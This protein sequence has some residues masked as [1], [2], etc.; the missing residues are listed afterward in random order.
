MFDS[1][2]RNQINIRRF[3]KKFNYKQIIKVLS[4]FAVIALILV[5]SLAVPV[6]ALSNVYQPKDYISRIEYEGN[7]EIV[8]YNFDVDPYYSVRNEA[9]GSTTND[10]GSVSIENVISQ[11]RYVFRIYP[12]GN[13]FVPGSSISGGV[14]DIRD[15]KSKAVFNFEV[16]VNFNIQYAYKTMAAGTTNFYFLSSVYFCFYDADGGFISQVTSSDIR[17]DVKLISALLEGTGEEYVLDISA[18][19]QI[20]ENAVYMAPCILSYLYPPDQN[21]DHLITRMDCDTKGFHLFVSK[22][23]LIEQSETLQAVED[24]LGDLNDKA[25]TMINGSQQQQNQAQDGSEKVEQNQQE[26]D[27]IL[28]QLDEYEKIDNTTAMEAIRNF[29]KENGW[30]DVREILGPLIDWG[31]TI[32]IMLIVLSL[33]NLSIILFGR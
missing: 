29:L 10:Y 11:K 6:M 32:T 13:N 19:M 26:M 4:S 5:A 3:T 1:G 23:L 25:D 24:Q 18:P 2:F 15:F 22:N 27:D 7:D 28:G 17:Y 9:N 12:L 30:L 20:P 14:I 21:A 33:I 8:Y 31:P 16:S